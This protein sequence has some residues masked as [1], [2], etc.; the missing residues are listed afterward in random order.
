[1]IIT[2]KIIIVTV[3]FLA[4][5]YIS[6]ILGILPGPAALPQY[7]FIFKLI[8]FPIAVYILANLIKMKEGI[9]LYAL[10]A[11]ILQVRYYYLGI[12]DMQTNLIM[13]AVHF[14]FIF[15]AFKISEK[16]KL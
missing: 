2:K 7:Y 11:L 14:A 3:L 16:I 9:L 4:L 5:D 6:H 10:S 1:M 12:Y 8:L 13:M 15:A